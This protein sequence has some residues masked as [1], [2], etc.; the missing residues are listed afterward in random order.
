MISIPNDNET[1][2]VDSGWLTVV[3]CLMSHSIK[4]GDED[5]NRILTRSTPFMAEALPHFPCFDLDSDLA[6]IGSR[7][8]KCIRWFKNLLVAINVYDDA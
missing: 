5:L 7:W 2:M 6:S 1:T 8:E 3:V 4:N